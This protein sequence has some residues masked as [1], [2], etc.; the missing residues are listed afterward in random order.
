[1]PATCATCQHLHVRR[2]SD[3]TTALADEGFRQ[4]GWPPC[5]SA[6]IPQGHWQPACNAG[7]PCLPTVG[8]L[9][10]EQF[11]KV[12]AEP[13]ECPAWSPVD[14]DSDAL[15]G[16]LDDLRDELD[17]ER[18]ARTLADRGLWRAI[19]ALWVWA[20]LTTLAVAWALS[21]TA[22]AP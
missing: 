2:R 3:N 9:Q 11:A 16:P 6:G 18:Q 10:P 8:R 4:T 13:R 5:D 15:G 19:A 20:A 12:L 22:Q 17:A 14:Y 7:M 1:M 21:R